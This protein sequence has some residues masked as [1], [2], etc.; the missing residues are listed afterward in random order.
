MID[1]EISVLI[2]RPVADV[3]NFVSNPLN[4]PLWQSML[5]EIKISTPGP[6]RIGSKFN[7][8]GEMMGRKLDGLLE[9]TELEPNTKFGYTGN[10]GPMQVHGLITFR[11]AGTGVRVGLKAHGEPGGVFKLAEGLLSNQIKTQMEAN[12]DRLKSVM[13][14]GA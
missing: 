14:S 3:Y 10:A 13:E 1:F 5:V 7:T 12:L 2:D 8:K 9:V 6:V 4:L 11:P